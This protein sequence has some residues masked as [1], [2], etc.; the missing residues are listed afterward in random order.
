[1]AA[2]QGGRLDVNR[3][4]QLQLSA[5]QRVLC[6][7]QDGWISAMHSETVGRASVLLGAGRMRKEDPI[8]FGAGIRLAVKRGTAV[9]KGDPLMTLY[10]AGESQLDEAEA[11]LRTAVCITDQAPEA[12]PLI[13]AVYTTEDF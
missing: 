3:P 7:E 13:H 1:M 8:D 2:A 10:A 5:C 11:M 6:A 4:D 12:M 9:Q